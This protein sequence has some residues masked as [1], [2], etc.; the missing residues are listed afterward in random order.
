M[1]YNCQPK[2]CPFT[3]FTTLKSDD[4]FDEMKVSTVVY[5]EIWV[6]NIVEFSN[7]L[8]VKFNNHA[9][10]N[11]S[12]IHMNCS[13]KFNHHH[14]EYLSKITIAKDSTEF[15]SYDPKSIYREF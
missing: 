15:Y 4:S 10:K 14:G 2:V 3:L 7:P 11:S 8:Y 1:Q 5:I 13:A 12:T 9:W 6:N